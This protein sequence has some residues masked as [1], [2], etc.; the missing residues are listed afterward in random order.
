MAYLGE[1]P[2]DVKDT[3]FADY[4]PADW[5]I[6]Y[7]GSYGQIDG[8][9]HK[10]WVLDQVSRILHGTP[11]EIVQA[12]WDDGSTEWRMTTGEPSEAYLEWVK[13]MKDEDE[14]GDEQYSYDEGRA[15]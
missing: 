6:Y 9:F 5:A 2:F 14:N 4:T 10:L 11:I 1:T 8:D 12:A 7:I 15:P 3:P 13:M